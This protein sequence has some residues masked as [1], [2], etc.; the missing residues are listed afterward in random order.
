MPLRGNMRGSRVT[1]VIGDGDGEWGEVRDMVVMEM[2]T[3]MMG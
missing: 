3:E 2:V 1:G